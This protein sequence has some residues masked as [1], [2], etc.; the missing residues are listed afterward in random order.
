MEDT[1][2][3][4]LKLVELNLVS[5]N[6]CCNGR[7]Y[8]RVSESK[9]IRSTSCLNPCCNG[10]YYQR[11]QKKQVSIKLKFVLILVVMED[12]LR[13]SETYESFV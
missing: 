10:R 8:Q 9:L 3:V 12:T 1:L 7:Y 13:E 4:K 5:L 2:R 11:V 6:P